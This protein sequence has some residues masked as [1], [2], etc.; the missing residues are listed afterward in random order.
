[1]SN[2]PG[3]IDTHAHIHMDYKD[4]DEVI[5][6]AGAAGVEQIITVGVDAA[7]SERAVALAQAYDN[8]FATVGLHPHDAALTDAALGQL[9]ALV[10]RPRVV[11]VG[12]CGLDYYRNLASKSDQKRAFE[13]QI[14]L[15]QKSNLPMVWHVRDAWDD[16]YDT[17]DRY[18]G[19]RGVV[20]CFTGNVFNMKRAVE[21]GFMVALNGIMTF[22]KD[23]D[24]L[25]AARKLP[26][27]HLVLETD[28]PFLTPAPRRGQRNEPALME[29][30]A[31]FLAELRGD[32]YEELAATSSANARRLFNLPTP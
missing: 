5:M 23:S 25:E 20:H 29:L 15:A 6:R 3:L 1:M 31:G 19:L 10:G 30:T 9:A 24:Q 18:D 32:S 13:S 26:L 8:V 28:C 16:F 7:D 27:D 4:V 2:K 22:T 12:E 21:R 11:A 14:E 17:V